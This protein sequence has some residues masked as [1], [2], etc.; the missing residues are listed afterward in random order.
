MASWLKDAPLDPTS[1][2]A[3][4][5]ERDRIA[6]Q[7][8]GVRL[9]GALVWVIAIVLAA[10][11]RVPEELTR[12]LPGAL[13]YLLVAGALFVAGRT[14]TL[15]RG[16]AQFAVPLVDVPMVLFIESIRVSFSPGQPLANAEFALALFGFMILLALMTLDRRIVAL[17]AVTAAAAE[18][19]LL[20]Q[21]HAPDY[22]W[23]IGALALIGL[24]AFTA[25]FISVRLLA[26]VRTAARERAEKERLA[27][28]FSPAVA[29]LIQQQGETATTGQ[30]C[31]VSI[32]FADIRDVT[33]MSERMESA[34]V[35]ALLNEYLSRATAS[36]PTSGGR[37]RTTTTPP[38]PWRAGSRCSRRSGRSTVPA[39]PAASRPST[40]ASAC[41][42]GGRWWGRSA[43]SCAGTTPWWA[44]R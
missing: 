19:W 15:P 26:I 24:V 10:Y 6:G 17:T 37:T 20:E 5:E 43:R 3:L 1:Q 29:V 40:W 36:W 42:A 33:A 27:R 44:M 32:L 31:E 41:T 34:E 13:A 35:V 23:W 2:R 30:H 22:S 39:R 9:A 38:R 16:I 28:H 18:L 8:R 12:N 11:D 25:M 21:A 4:D 7:L 14:G